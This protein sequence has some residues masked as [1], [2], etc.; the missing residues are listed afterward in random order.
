MRPISRRRFAEFASCTILTGG[1][2]TPVLG[3][4]VQSDLLDR[5]ALTSAKAVSRVLLGATR[6]GKR[7]VA[8]GERGVIVVSDDDGGTWRQAATPVSVSLTNVRFIDAGKGWVV[9]HGGVV[10]HTQD[11]GESWVKQ[12]DGRQAA[13]LLL[14]AAKA[15]QPGAGADAQRALANAQRTVDEGPGK[16]FLDVHF[17]D[18]DNGL[19][20]GAFGLVFA[21]S[22]GG[23]TWQPA[24]DRIDNPKG[25][26]LYSVQANGAE[27][28][29][30]GE[31]GAVFR[32]GDRGKTF[33]T[34]N[35]PYAGTYFGVVLAA[36]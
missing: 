2:L 23:K 34:L 35:T 6:A 26:H 12:L 1:S 9:G 22:D 31:Q 30:V 27:C 33:A 18:G 7:I 3:A 25:K 36:P 8:V 32:S 20:V 16:P 10:L 5:P 19:I 24:L 14:Q 28:F 4:A 15:G 13:Q 21:T 17:F 29:V 11:G